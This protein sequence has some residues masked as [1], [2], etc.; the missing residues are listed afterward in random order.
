VNVAASTADRAARVDRL[1]QTEKQYDQ[2]WKVASPVKRSTYDIPIRD[3]K[4]IRTELRTFFRDLADHLHGSPDELAKLDQAELDALRKKLEANVSGGIGKHVDGVRWVDR[5]YLADMGETNVRG[6]IEKLADAINNPI[7]TADIYTSPAYALNLVGNLGMAGITQGVKTFPALQRAVVANRADG[8]A[9][10]AVIDSVMGA[11]QSRSY[12]VPTGVAHQAN[13]R[14]AEGWNAITDLYSR[15]GAFYHEAGRAGFKT[16]EEINSLLHDPANRR[17]LVE[18]T[19][20][21]NK[22]MV[23]FSSLTPL[24]QNTIRRLLFFYPWMSRGTLWALRTMVENPGKT[25]T[26]AQLAQVGAANAHKAFPGGLPSWADQQGLIPVG[27]QHGDLLK[28][29]NPSSINTYSTAAQA[30]R[31]IFN[32]AKGFAGFKTSA[33]SGLGGV[34]TPGAQLFAQSA[35]ASPTGGSLPGI[36]GALENTPQGQ[37]L[38]RAGVYGKPP[39]SYPGTGAGDVYGPYLG[40]G[41]YPRDISASALHKQYVKELPADKRA[42]VHLEDNRKAFIASAKAAGVTLPLAGLKKA[43]GI[44]EQRAAGY[45]RLGS[46]PTQKAKL[47]VD[48]ALAVKLGGLKRQDASEMLANA[49]TATDAEIQAA[50]R[51]IN[52]AF[53]YGKDLAEARRYVKI[54]TASSAS[55]AGQPARTAAG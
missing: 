38:R 28:V 36:P 15:R 31:V 21:A 1:L 16:P 6:P 12:S 46:K 13:Q 4:Q 35:G 3:T 11:S 51:Q 45:A 17:K 25:F 2:M 14:L 50:R 23:D 10:T 40:H 7:R 44:Q 19:R 29:I 27:S 47:G 8:E 5:R 20:R 54:A 37:L 55:R 48:L 22:N 9:N 32:T 41:A 49:N 52:S 39:A 26:L 42:V 34:L 53:F 33:Q 30:G 18:V 43:Y 24:E